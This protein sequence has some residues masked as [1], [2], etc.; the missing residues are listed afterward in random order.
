MNS[1]MNYKVGHRIKLEKGIM[2]RP[3]KYMVSE[4]REHIYRAEQA[5]ARKG[6]TAAVLS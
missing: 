5:M 3:A 2:E 6:S 1:K 4:L